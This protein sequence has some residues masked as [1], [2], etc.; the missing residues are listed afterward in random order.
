MFNNLIRQE[1]LNLDFFVT[2]TYA[3]KYICN[4]F[5]V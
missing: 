2:K 3:Y 5:N 4:L 1:F